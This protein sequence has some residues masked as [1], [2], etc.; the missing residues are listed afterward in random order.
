MIFFNRQEP[1]TLKKNTMLGELT[2]DQIESFLREQIIGRLACADG[3][4]IFLVP[5]T[6]VYERDYIYCHTHEGLKI[7]IMRKNPSVCFEVD[8]MENFANWK[9][10]IAWGK[11]EELH[12]NDA[13]EGALVVSNRLK[14]FMVSE[15]AN[16]HIGI[17]DIHESR[18]QK[19]KSVVFRIKVEKKTGR[20]ERR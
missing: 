6:Y 18:D 4:Q 8:S 7:D 5:I 15:T 2:N 3:E 16:S 11:F 10:V 14:P 17:S 12:G 19:S 1:S 9:S 20:F 13:V